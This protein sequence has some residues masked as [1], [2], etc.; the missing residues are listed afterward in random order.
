MPIYEIA[1]LLHILSA[2]VLFGTG[3]GTAYFMWR[4]HLTADPRQIAV[5]AGHV[6]AADWFFTAP[7]VVAQPLTGALLIVEIGYD[8][9]EGWILGAAGLYLLAGVCWL[10][11]VWLQ[12]RMRDLARDAAARGS[13]LPD[14]YRRIAHFWFALGWPAFLAVIAIFILMVFRPE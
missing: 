2:A 3:L 10:P 7:A 1:K 9:T 4:A 8:W 14:A 12:I 11:V 6:V 5:T 13:P